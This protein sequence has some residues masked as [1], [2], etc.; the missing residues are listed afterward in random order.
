MQAGLGGGKMQ[1]AALSPVRVSGLAG[2]AA[3]VSDWTASRLN[4]A[5]GVGLVDGEV[6]EESL[7]SG[8]GALGEG[9]VVGDVAGHR[10]GGVERRAASRRRAP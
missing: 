6:G 9:E 10:A 4:A 3:G 7:G 2:I 8:R 5:S 1:L